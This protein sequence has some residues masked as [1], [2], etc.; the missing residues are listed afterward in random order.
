MSISSHTLANKEW[1]F[2]DGTVKEFMSVKFLDTKY[3]FGNIVKEA[4]NRIE[5]VILN[6]ELYTAAEQYIKT[7][8]VNGKSIQMN[9]FD[10]VEMAQYL[11]Y[12]E[13]KYT[14]ATPLIISGTGDQSI[15]G[16]APIDGYE[17]SLNA[18]VLTHNG[19]KN[20]RGNAGKLA[21]LTGAAIIHEVM[22][23]HGY[24]H[25]GNPGELTYESSFPEI[26]GEA[27]LKQ[28]F[29]DNSLNGLFLTATGIPSSILCKSN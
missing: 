13:F 7:E 20:F 9:G 10:Y 19:H 24:R 6:G 1:K 26:A 27:F 16:S 8:L 17:V 5:R 22:H 29:P 12:G 21:A 28:Q 15:F 4:M 14:Q 25:S 2:A 18:A 23:N 3:D 11:K